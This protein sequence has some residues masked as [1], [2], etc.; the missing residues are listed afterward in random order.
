L[1]V[2]GVFN[3]DDTYPRLVVAGQSGYRSVR[4]KKTTLRISRQVRSNIAEFYGEW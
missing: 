1:Y 4:L 3:I 2:F